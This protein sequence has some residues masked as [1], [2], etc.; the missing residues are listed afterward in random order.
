MSKKVV[1]TKPEI[2]KYTFKN[3]F[4]VEFEIV[5][6]ATLYENNRA[7]LIVPHRTSF[8]HILLFKD[9]VKSH[10]VDFR[11]LKIKSGA[12][13]FFNK[14]VVQQFNNNPAKGTAILFSADFFARTDKDLRALKGSVLFNDL[15][16]IATIDTTTADPSILQLFK[17]LE[18]EANKAFDGFQADILHNYLSNLLLY[19]EREYRRTSFRQVTKSDELDSTLQFK[20]LVEMHFRANRQVSFFIKKMNITEKRLNKATTKILG[21]TP[22]TVIDERVILECKR[23]L[24]YSS[25]SV[26]EIGYELGFDEPTNFIKY[27]KKHTAITPF[28][29]RNNFKK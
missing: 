6:F 3:G 8:Y 23:L 11:P 18:A 16:E 26:K 5:S 22:K 29:F 9:D 21:K 27:F 13:V 28:E 12:L 10:N 25:Q 24:S 14:D 20:D 15:F 19:S 4:P 17:A 2:K 7:A 1:N